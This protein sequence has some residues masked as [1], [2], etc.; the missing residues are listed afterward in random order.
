MTV[1]VCDLGSSPLATSVLKDDEQAKETT[2]TSYRNDDSDFEDDDRDTEQEDYDMVDAQL[3]ENR[4]PRSTST[5]ITADS[6]HRGNGSHIDLST[7]GPRT[8]RSCCLLS[9]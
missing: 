1:A 5:R 7:S 6:P 9:S 2:Y 3:T 8:W 4:Q